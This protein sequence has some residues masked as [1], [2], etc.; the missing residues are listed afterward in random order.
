MPPRRSC[1]APERLASSRRSPISMP[2][3]RSCFKQWWLFGREG[4]LDFNAT[5]AFLLPGAKP[6][7]G[8]GVAG[9]Q[10][11]HGV[12]ASR[13]RCAVP[14]FQHHFNA[15]TAF[16]LRTPIPRCRRPA[17]RFQCHHGIP[18]SRR[19]WRMVFEEPE[20]Q[21]H[22]GVP[23]SPPASYFRIFKI[24]FNATTA[25][26]LPT[27]RVMKTPQAGEISMPPRRSCFAGGPG[28]P[29]PDLRHFNAT[30]A[31][32]LPGWWPSLSQR[33]SSFQCHHGVPASLLKAVAASLLRQFQCHHGVPASSRTPSFPPLPHAVSMPPRRSCFSP[34]STDGG[35]KCP[36]FN[37]TTAFLLRSLRALG[38][39]GGEGF[40]ATTAFLLHEQGR[41]V[42]TRRLIVSMPPRRSCFG[43]A[44]RAGGVDPPQFQCHHG[45]P[46]SP[47]RCC[48]SR[49]GG[50]FQCHHGVPA[51]PRRCCPSRVGG[52]FQ[53]HH[54]VPASLLYHRVVDSCQ[55][56]DGTS[57]GMGIV[58]FEHRSVST[59]P[60]PLPRPSHHRRS[61]EAF[62]ELSIIC[63]FHSL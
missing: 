63:P 24:N 5:T 31:F 37:A 18:A 61:A 3:R 8:C 51:S 22:H 15:T 35:T 4:R 49:V 27:V 6:P 13:I 60:S 14:T 1:F 47:R 16:L 53:C 29:R 40:N 19:A 38:G 46:A 9:F 34:G 59:A 55:V 43:P 21:C 30:T 62:S 10:C 2:P 20:F 17:G 58:G 52:K 7:G 12:P 32:L 33:I 57:K 39:R 41:I 44:G 23:A 11:H 36:R 50:K 28:T 26:L 42:G 56:R 48:P 25:F 54:G 45:V